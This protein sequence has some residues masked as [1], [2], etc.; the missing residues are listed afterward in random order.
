[1][2]STV[3]KPLI[4]SIHCQRNLKGSCL[5]IE[6]HFNA[7]SIGSPAV[8]SY[9]EWH[10]PPMFLEFG[11]YCKKNIGISM[12]ERKTLS[13]IL[14]FVKQALLL[15]IIHCGAVTVLY[16]FSPYSHFTQPEVV[17]NQNN[18]INLC[19]IP[20]IA[21]LCLIGSSTIQLECSVVFYLFLCLKKNP[22]I[23]QL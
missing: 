20:S 1:M 14:S 19:S 7:S 2:G 4:R 11:L 16:F 22:T 5:K 21:T 18:I 8:A 6:K 9:I 17:S 12:P 10:I 13:S 15:F 23:P 3:A